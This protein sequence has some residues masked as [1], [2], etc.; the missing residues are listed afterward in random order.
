M[1][2]D[3]EKVPRI[4]IERRNRERAAAA[5]NGPY[6][7]Q[8][9]TTTTPRTSS[10]DN[11]TPSSSSNVLS[12][13]SSSTAVTLPPSYEVDYP[14]NVKEWKRFA[15][16][17]RPYT[18]LME[19]SSR[20][21]QE[22]VAILQPQ[23]SYFDVDVAINDQLA[24]QLSEWCTSRLS[25][26]A[27]DLPSPL[28][29]RYSRLGGFVTSTS[30]EFLLELVQYAIALQRMPNFHLTFTQV[31]THVI[32]LTSQILLSN[33]SRK[34]AT[35]HAFELMVMFPFATPGGFTDSGHLA[36]IAKRTATI[37]RYEFEIQRAIRGRFGTPD[38]HDGEQEE[39]K[40]GVKWCST[41][42]W[43]AVQWLGN[44]MLS[45][46]VS[47]ST[48]PPI[49]DIRYFIA[50]LRRSAFPPSSIAF[51]SRAFIL[52]RALQLACLQALAPKL[53]GGQKSA[54]VNEKREDIDELAAELRSVLKLW[55]DKEHE[56]EA[57]RYEL[58]TTEPV[59][60]QSHVL[61]Q[62]LHVES[63]EINALIE[64]YTVDS[65]FRNT[66]LV[67]ASRFYHFTHQ[68]MSFFAVNKEG[69]RCPPVL[70]TLLMECSARL[71]AHVESALFTLGSLAMVFV[72]PD[73]SDLS[74]LLPTS[75]VCGYI[76]SACVMAMESHAMQVKYAQT[77]PSRHESFMAAMHTVL[78]LLSRMDENARLSNDHGNLVRLTTG[79]VRRFIDVLFGWKRS[80][81]T[82]GPSLGT[83]IEELD[84]MEGEV[85]PFDD[86]DRL[87]LYVQ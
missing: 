63:K 80:I 11:G 83:S 66:A 46:A 68:D 50:M 13:P 78:L 31:V 5:H 28:F 49:R 36:S 22:P 75:T 79:I 55:R 14:D 25:T 45:F 60:P 54:V 10:T 7:S 19:Y 37:C 51:T 85:S 40:Q 52:L 65:I 29:L 1:L 67:Q 32:Q 59:H 24:I 4:R 8:P 12:N 41:S 3:P 71:L 27:P 72:S 82:S 74:L 77:L 48:M 61:M 69:H 23:A 16:R 20:L 17:S 2:N 15:I 64:G 47:G 44:D 86:N 43:E 76:L 56:L 73:P 42:C 9:T 38:L 62:F 30:A 26:W 81:T 58:L 33:E 57:L 84:S 53:L 70:N 87:A 21:A 35:A 34:L 39:L 6:G 18:L